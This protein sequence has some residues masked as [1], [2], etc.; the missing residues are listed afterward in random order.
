MLVTERVAR[1]TSLAGKLKRNDVNVLTRENAVRIAIV[2]VILL[3]GILRFSGRNWDEGLHL[4][5]DERFITMVATDIRWP[6]SIGEY[7]NS[8]ES[9]LNPY[10]AKNDDDTNKYGSFI[11]GTFPLFLGKAVADFTG[12]DDY[13]NFPL[14]SRGLSATFDL[15]TVFL[16]FLVGRRLFGEFTGLLA[17]L[18]MSLSVLN[19]QL[20][21]FGTFDTFVTMLCLATFYFAIRANDTGSWRSYALAGIAAGLAIASKLS[22]LPVIFMVGLPLAEAIR[23]R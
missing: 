17:S 6:A 16:V 18:L 10:N 1:Y 13:G 22:A 7:F 2:A 20:S 4:H 11:Y 5:P 12:N 14:A 15:V 21:H 3:G 23:Q 9:P 8:E 19:I